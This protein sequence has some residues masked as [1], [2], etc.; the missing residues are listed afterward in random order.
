MDVN[1]VPLGFTS[2]SLELKIF[3]LLFERATTIQLHIMTTTAKI[4]V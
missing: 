2:S 3:S 1:D 4:K